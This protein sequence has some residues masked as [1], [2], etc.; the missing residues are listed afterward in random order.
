MQLYKTQCEELDTWSKKYQIKDKEYEFLR[1]TNL[2]L[3]AEHEKT[4]KE[5]NE[6]IEKHE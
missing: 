4:E 2:R 5:L 1:V 6:L 3:Q